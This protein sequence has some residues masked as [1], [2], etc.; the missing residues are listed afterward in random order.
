MERN[1]CYS[2]PVSKMCFEDMANK[3]LK[4]FVGA[5]RW[6]LILLMYV[7]NLHDGFESNGKH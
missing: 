3:F 4:D 7:T 5:L 2:L 6:I 1:A